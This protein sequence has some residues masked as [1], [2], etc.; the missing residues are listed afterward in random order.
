MTV[1]G[2]AKTSTAKTYNAAIYVDHERPTNKL[3]VAPLGSNM[4]AALRIMQC[5][6]H[7]TEGQARMA[8]PRAK[9]KHE[10]SL[11]ARNLRGK[12]QTATQNATNTQI[13]LHTYSGWEHLSRKAARNCLTGASMANKTKS[14]RHTLPA[15]LSQKIPGGVMTMMM[16]RSWGRCLKRSWGRC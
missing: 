3:P 1:G 7:W 12:M 15:A 16:K 2:D 11:P 8:A 9:P 13:L 10:A 4:Q 6:G 5:L 14:P